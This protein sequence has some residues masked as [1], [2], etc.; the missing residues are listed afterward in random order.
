M[1][2]MSKGRNDGS[3]EDEKKMR[4]DSPVMSD[5]ML[6]CSERDWGE[7]ADGVVIVDKY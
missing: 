4:T 5:Y 3:F 1:G 2:A 6:K 7:G